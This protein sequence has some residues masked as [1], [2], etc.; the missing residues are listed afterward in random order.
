MPI[1]ETALRP[2]ERERSEAL[3][4]RLNGLS[5]AIV[6]DPMLDHFIFGRVNRISPEAPVPVVEFE[7]ED[8]RVGG[9]GNVAHNARALGASVKLVG[10]VGR[11]E[12]GTRLKDA[13]R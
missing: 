13:L 10:L 5:I 9:A 4:R 3:L 2:V 6:G 11:D 7:R 8:F 1:P 12:P